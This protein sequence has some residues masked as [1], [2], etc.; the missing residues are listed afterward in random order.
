MASTA[1]RPPP[2]VSP[3]AASTTSP[4]D[5]S[6]Y[7]P[8]T[9]GHPTCVIFLVQSGE[10]NVFD[11]RYL[12]YALTSSTPSI[13]VF[14][15]PFSSIQ[16]ST[17]LTPTRHLLYRPTAN[18]SLTYEVAVAYLYAGYSPGIVQRTI[19]KILEV[20][21]FG[22]KAILEEMAEKAIR[23]AILEETAEKAIRQAILEETVEKAIRQA[24]PEETVEKAIRQVAHGRNI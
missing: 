22:N 21:H 4:W 18:L 10:R 8:L 20:K 15:L 5:F 19:G 11:Q 2:A 7:G 12:E 13:P 9:L 14:R 6:A 16:N 3:S 17:T 1:S 23:Q 24:I